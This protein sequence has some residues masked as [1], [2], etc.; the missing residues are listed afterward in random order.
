MNKFI[1]RIF[2]PL[3]AKPAAP[4]LMQQKL[5]EYKTKLVEAEDAALYAEKMSEYYR[6]GIE[7]L[8]HQMELQA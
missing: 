1:K 4:T 6:E 3:F 7:R 8:Q 2:A 5:H